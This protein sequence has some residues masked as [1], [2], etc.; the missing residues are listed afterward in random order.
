MS[1]RVGFLG[2][3]TDAVSSKSE[4]LS[5]PFLRLTSNSPCL[6][7]LPANVFVCCTYK[8][9]GCSPLGRGNEPITI[10]VLVV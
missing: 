10:F 1:L 9:R 3:C 4:G 6:G 8:Q 5:E 2:T 7:F